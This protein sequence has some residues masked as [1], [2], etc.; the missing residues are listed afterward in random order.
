MNT[1]AKGAL[2]VVA[3]VAA[4]VMVLIAGL[5]HSADAD[6]TDDQGGVQ[7]VPPEYERWIRQAVAECPHPELTPALMAA[8]IQQESGFNAGAGSDAGAQGPAQFVP[9]TWATWGRDADANGRAD[10]HDIG[11]A[12]V[13]Q[14]R[15][16][17]SLLGTAKESQLR[18]DPRRLALAGYNAGWG[19]VQRFGGVPPVTFADGETY[20]YV[21]IIMASMKKFEAAGPAGTLA[22]RGS[23]RG[24]DALRRAAHY[25]GT[26][27]SYGGGTPNGPGTGF[28]DGTNGYANGRCAAE[29]T[30]GFDCSSLVQ[31]GYWTSV[32][33]PRTAAAQYN[34]TSDRP[35]TRGNLKP[36]DLVFWADRS[37]FI[38][39]VGLYAG[40]GRVL[41]APRTGRDVQVQP[42]D[43]AMPTA[44]YHGATRP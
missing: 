24:P 4:L 3:G 34:A 10:P 1:I 21:R 23:G 8:Q 26:P 39:H 40:E 17:C 35:V 12:V 42:L 43:T 15:F 25:I 20:H 33:L 31:Y 16:M 11:D 29:S 27:Y 7:G 37:G 5:L 2:L 41:H 19:A 30:V 13:A 36:G 32:Q 44:D 18:D 14:G 6:T 38:Y 22:V 28:C 9:G